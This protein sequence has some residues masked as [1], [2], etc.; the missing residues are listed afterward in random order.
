VKEKSRNLCERFR[1]QEEYAMAKTS[2]AV[3]VGKRVLCE[4]GW[5]QRFASE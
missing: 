3:E 4:R 2:T 5:R 1:A